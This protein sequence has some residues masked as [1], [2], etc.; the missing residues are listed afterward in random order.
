LYGQVKVKRR[1]GRLHRAL[2]LSGNEVKGKILRPTMTQSFRLLAN[3]T[4]EGFPENDTI[5]I[6]DMLA[7]IKQDVSITENAVLKFK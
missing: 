3:P 7:K 6:N 5:D 2:I 1:F 4:W